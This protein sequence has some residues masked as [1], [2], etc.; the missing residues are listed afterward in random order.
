MFIISKLMAFFISPLN[1]IVLLTFLAI[2][3][4]KRQKLLLWTTFGLFLFF[5]N[6]MIF[7]GVIKHWEPAPTALPVNDSSLINVVVLGGMASYYEPTARVRFWQSGDRLMQALAI[8]HQNP[9][10]HLV[11][12]GGSSAVLLHESPEGAFLSE[13]LTQS[14]VSAQVKIEVDSLSRN[15]FENALYTSRI[16]ERN[17]WDKKIA[18]VTSAWHMKRAQWCFNQFGF[19]VTPIG[20]DPMYPLQKAVP[21]DYFMPSAQVLIN[22]QILVKEW[23]GWLAYKVRY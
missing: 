17:G 5:S 1:I 21:A 8:V 10:T 11:I 9:V 6:S 4:K 12:S 22:W 3:L 14:G 19:E 16:F 18:L 20:A 13:F 7:R 15:T 23:V 2:I